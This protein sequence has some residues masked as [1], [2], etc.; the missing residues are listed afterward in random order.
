MQDMNRETSFLLQ[1]RNA[2]IRNNDR[3]ETDTQAMA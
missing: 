2:L 1:T 3:R